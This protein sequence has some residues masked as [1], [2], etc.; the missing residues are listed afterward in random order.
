[1]AAKINRDQSSLLHRS[2]DNDQRT[3]HITAAPAIRQY[4]ARENWRQ[5]GNRGICRYKAGHH[6]EHPRPDR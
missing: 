4:Q 2:G 3:S 6:A 1:M 5:L